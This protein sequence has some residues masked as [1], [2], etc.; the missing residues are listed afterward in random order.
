VCAYD[1]RKRLEAG[2]P[3]FWQNKANSVPAAE[4]I[5]AEQSHPLRLT[6]GVLAEQS[7]PGSGSPEAFWQNKANP[8]RQPGA[9]GRTKPTAPA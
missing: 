5:L 6:G 1:R 4:R 9:F 2:L 7:Q 8:F 3:A